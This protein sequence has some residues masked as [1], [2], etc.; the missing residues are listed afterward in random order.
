[1]KRHRPCYWCYR[2]TRGSIRFPMVGE[3]HR[4][5]AC[6]EHKDATR[7]QIAKLITP[8]FRL[9]AAVFG[10]VSRMLGR[11]VTDGAVRNGDQ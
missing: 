6:S 9:L 10:D 7:E 1:M 2:P 3:S 4:I 8:S 5:I 11:N